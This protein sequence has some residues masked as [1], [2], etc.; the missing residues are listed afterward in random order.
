MVPHVSL[1]KEEM[2]QC[3]YYTRQIQVKAL[4]GI[5][6]FQNLNGN[7]RRC[8]CAVHLST[9]ADSILRLSFVT[10]TDCNHYGLMVRD[11]GDDSLLFGCD[12]LRPLTARLYSTSHRVL[13]VFSNSGIVIGPH[14]NFHITFTSVSARVEERH[15]LQVLFDSPTSG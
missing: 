10:A 15:K 2:W 12:T 13:L 5:I 6:R 1:L 3:L 7:G 9:L 4:T 14:G 11:E 8:Y